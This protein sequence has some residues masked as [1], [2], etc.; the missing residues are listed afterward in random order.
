MKKVI[1]ILAAVAHISCS[2]QINITNQL[3]MIPLKVGENAPIQFETLVIEPVNLFVQSKP[4]NDRS[5]HIQ[6]ELNVKRNSGE[7]ATF[8]WYYETDSDPKTNYPKAFENYIFGLEI[9]NDSVRLAVEK[10]DFGKDFFLELNQKAIIGNISISF[11]E[12]YIKWYVHPFGEPNGHCAI[13]VIEVS[14]GNEQEEIIFRFYSDDR[15]NELQSEW[16]GYQFSLVEAGEKIF[17][18]KVLEK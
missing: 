11:K 16:K 7:Y 9:N 2:G 13:Y 12:Y 18:L 17:K 4:W 14:G 8:L 15:L 6:L 5:P 1:I 3:Y 10:L